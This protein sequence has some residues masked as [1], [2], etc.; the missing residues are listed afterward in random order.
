MK[1]YLVSVL[2]HCG[3]Y[4]K[5]TRLLVKAESFS[6][7][8]DYAI[9][10]E[11]HDPESLDWSEDRVFDLGGEFAYSASVSKVKRSDVNVLLKYL[12][13]MTADLDELNASGNYQSRT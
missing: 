6:L 4:E 11:S 12:P 5:T 7:A 2:I 9:Y 13:C 1:T 8:G 10:S 3:E